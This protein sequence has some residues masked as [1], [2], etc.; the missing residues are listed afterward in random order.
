MYSLCPRKWGYRYLMGL[1]LQR[2]K[3]AILGS[4]IHSCLEAHLTG[5]TVYGFTLDKETSAD[6]AR[7]EPSERDRMTKE[8]PRRALAGLHLLPQLNDPA[9]ELVEK[10]GALKIDAASI[11]PHYTGLAA[12]PLA[13][14]GK[15]DLTM[16]RAGAWYLYDHKST[17]G[18]PK[19][20]WAYAL[21][22]HEL[23]ADPQ[24]ALYSASVIQKHGLAE[25]WARWV[26]YLT[27]PKA[28]PQ[29]HAVDV[30]I[31]REESFA[32]A[33]QWLRLAIEMRA[34][35]RMVRLGHITGEALTLH[36][37]LLPKVSPADEENSP[38]KAYGGCGYGCE[39]G[40]PCTLPLEY[41]A[42][43]IVSA[44]QLNP[45]NRKEEKNMF[46]IIPHSQD[47]SGFPAPS[48]GL[49][50][51][52]VATAEK[53]GGEWMQLPPMPTN[54]LSPG[55]VWALLP[56]ATTG[57]PEWRPAQDPSA[58]PVASPPPPGV[59]FT[60]PEASTPA[61]L[62]QP[63]IPVAPGAPVAPP[64]AP[65]SAPGAKKPGRPKKNADQAALPLTASG[66]PAPGVP[67][68][69]YG[70]P[71]TDFTRQVAEAVNACKVNGLSEVRLHPDG[72]LAGVVLAPVD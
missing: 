41:G 30:R 11:L 50:W 60:S 2:G 33:A 62:A 52:L 25:L 71:A 49:T 29:A 67:A 18:K 56:H 59:P 6:L 42:G 28:H 44:N 27:D 54:P 36:D 34:W 46:R 55:F 9:I 53:P 70:K 7:L 43:Q 21:K 47:M 66:H 63:A 20:P 72:S 8:A 68:E 69:G 35:T 32:S 48:P 64:S 12:D 58:P 22:P 31:S 39:K 61:A 24:G 57:Q 5:K 19:E 38:C 16:R 40:G 1:R 26:Y 45:A 15:L 17:I 13:F 3:S 10:E 51:Q 65:G 23:V 14:V 37:R 4:V